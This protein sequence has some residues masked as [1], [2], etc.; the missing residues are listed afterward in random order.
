MVMTITTP[1]KTWFWT[2]QNMNDKKLDAQ[3][4]SQ[5]V[6]DTLR[7]LLTEIKSN[8]H[9]SFNWR[10][11]N[12]ISTDTCNTMQTVWNTLASTDEL[13]HAFMVPCDSHGLQLVVKDILSLPSV[14]PTYKSGPFL[15]TSS[16]RYNNGCTEI[17]SKRW[18]TNGK[19]CWDYG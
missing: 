19:K 15:R 2:L 4:I 18:M 1:S 7:L 10:Q 12:S 9:E 6:M 5:W 13:R 8:A 17:V 3:N 14:K 16:P 11:V